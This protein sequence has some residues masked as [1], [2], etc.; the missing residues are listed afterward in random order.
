MADAGDGIL[1]EARRVLEIE[2]EAIRTVAGRLDGRFVRAVELLEACQ[3]RVVATGMGKSGLIGRKLAATLAA[4]GTPALFL[5]P[6]E[7]A[8]GDLGVLAPGDVVVAVSH[9]GETEEVL[10]LLPAIKRLGL[11]LVVLTGRL[12]SRLAAEADVV[13]DVSVREEACP[14]GLTPTA[15]ST[16]ALALGDGLAVAVLSRRGFQA[17]DFALLHPGGR[18][19]RRLLRVEELMHTGSEVPVVSRHAPLQEV[20]REMSLKRLGATAVVDDHGRLTGI[21][22][23]GDLRR[24]FQRDRLGPQATA[25]DVMSRAPKSVGRTDLA[26]AALALMETHAITQLLVVDRAG[27]PDGIIHLHDLL[28]ARVA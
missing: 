28:R 15:S 27:R 6:A 16:A 13:L 12:A 22:T 7:A 25:T 17:E 21:V 19:G 10:N 5:H 4:T 20:V 18:L 3:G 14:L 26:A 24:A 8:H 9:S 2:A 1:T 11:A 23:D